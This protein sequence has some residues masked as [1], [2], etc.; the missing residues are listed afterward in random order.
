MTDTAVRPATGLPGYRAGTWTVD[1]SHSELGF[2][3]RHMMV[4]KVRGRFT[5]FTGSLTTGEDARDS[6][7]E[8]TAELASIDTGNEQ[9][10]TH[11]RSA[12]FFDADKNPQMTFRS[13]DIRPADDRFLVDGD[14]TIR[15]VTRPVTFEVGFNGIGPDAF[16]GTRLGLSASTEINRRDWGVNWNAAI[17]GGGVVVGEKVQINVEIEAVLDT[18]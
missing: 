8:I 15:G 12:D 17:E 6:S 10:D 2:S 18:N 4:S 16:G 11:L 9:R 14:L 1:P 5:R 3:V 7:A 13:T